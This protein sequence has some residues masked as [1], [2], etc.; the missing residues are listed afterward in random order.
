V[1][2]VLAAVATTLREK[3]ATSPSVATGIE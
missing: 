2:A 3:P 1:L